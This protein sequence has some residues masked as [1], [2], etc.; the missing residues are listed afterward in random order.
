MAERVYDLVDLELLKESPQRWSVRQYELM[1]TCEYYMRT[2]AVDQG[3]RASKTQMRLLI[4]S[5]MAAHARELTFCPWDDDYNRKPFKPFVTEEDDAKPTTAAEHVLVLLALHDKIGCK[6]KDI[7]A[8][9]TQHGY[10]V[11]AVNVALADL[12]KSGSIKRIDHG[13]YALDRHAGKKPVV[14]AALA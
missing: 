6:R 1:G 11:S 13:V 14:R 8:A 9:V 7:N 3:A 4:R 2:R 12:E 5:A 10:S